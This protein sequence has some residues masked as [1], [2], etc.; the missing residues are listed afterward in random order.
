MR[1]DKMYKL[2]TPEELEMIREVL[3]EASER[4]IISISNQL[5]DSRLSEQE[6]RD[7]IIG[8]YKEGLDE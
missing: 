1:R 5:K 4:A 7:A 8:E 2:Q 6:V 3:K